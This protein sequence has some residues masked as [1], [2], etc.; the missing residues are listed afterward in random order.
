MFEIRKTNRRLGEYP[1]ADHLNL[2][3]NYLLKEENL[4][5]GAI[6][7][8]CYALEKAGAYYYENV[9]DLLVQKGIKQELFK[10]NVVN[11]G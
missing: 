11:K 9:L 6:E 5:V 8:I 10:D 3:L 7:E 4:N 1:C 2:A